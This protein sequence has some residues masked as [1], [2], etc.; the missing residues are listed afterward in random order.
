MT[1]GFGNKFYL[2]RM[3]FS[4]HSWPMIFFAQ[5]SNALREER[6]SSLKF[7]NA[8]EKHSNFT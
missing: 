8:Y 6:N 4:K 2:Y 1:I 5:F 7:T 3:I